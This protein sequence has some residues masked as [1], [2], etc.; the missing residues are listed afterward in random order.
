MYITEK[1]FDSSPVFV[2]YYP[3]KIKSFYMPKIDPGSDIEHV[4]CF[5]LLF[6]KFGEIVGGSQREHNYAKLLARMDE[7][8]VKKE[9]MKFYID[10]RKYGSV[11]HGGSGIGIDRLLMIITGMDNIRDMIPYPRSYQTS[12]F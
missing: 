5:D 7:S 11:P 10:M 2:R 8:G 12:L 9:T 3:A 6:P 4:D 1:L